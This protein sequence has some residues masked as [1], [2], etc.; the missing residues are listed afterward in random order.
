MA[1]LLRKIHLPHKGHGCL[2]NEDKILE[3]GNQLPTKLSLFT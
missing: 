3:Y 2:F 1:I